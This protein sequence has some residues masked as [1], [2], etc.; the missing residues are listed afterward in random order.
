MDAHDGQPDGR[1]IKQSLV[2]WCYARYWTPRQMCEVARELGCQSI[3]VIDVEH[4]PCL[5]EFGLTCAL[6]GSHGFVQGLNNPRHHEACLAKLRERIDQAAAFGCP[7]VITFSGNRDGMSGGEGQ[8]HCVRAL[9]QIIG[10]AERQHVNL[11]L[12]MLNSRVSEEMKGHPG[13][14]GD[15]VDWCVE[16]INRV[17]SPQMKLLFDIYHVQIMDG[18]IIT[19]LRKY[20]DLIGHIHTAGVPGRF[21]LHGRQE[22]NY[23]QIME[24][25]AELGYEGYVGH[26]FFSTQPTAEFTLESLRKAVAMCDV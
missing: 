9:K 7:N 15:H 3:E 4:W 20:I 1:R 2:Y 19:R 26:E 16:V 14:M 24:V 8:E 12:E 17:G 11:C 21:E 5:Q 6:A 23:R 22:I 25:L 13:Y 18:D 10:H